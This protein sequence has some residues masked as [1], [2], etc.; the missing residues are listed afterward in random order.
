MQRNEEYVHF[1]IQIYIF[2]SGTVPKMS[3][4]S[5]KGMNGPSV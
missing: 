1:Q 2:F 5:D 3:G 4:K